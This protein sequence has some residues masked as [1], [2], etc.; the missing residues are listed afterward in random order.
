[1]KAPFETGKAIFLAKL[2]S[3]QTFLSDGEISV[4][5]DKAKKFQFVLFAEVFAK[6][7]R[8]VKKSLHR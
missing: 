2:R 3:S 8:Q 1:M 5:Q 7:C 6:F 4:F